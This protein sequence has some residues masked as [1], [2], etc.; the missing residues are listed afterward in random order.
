MGLAERL[1]AGL[2][3]QLQEFNSPI[4]PQIAGVKFPGKVF[5][6]V[7]Q[8][9]E[10]AVRIGEAESSI[11]SCSTKYETTKVFAIRIRCVWPHWRSHNRQHAGF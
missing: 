8:M 7:A 2:W 10:R 5:G 9:G 4:P 3:T 6:A 11:L 1:G